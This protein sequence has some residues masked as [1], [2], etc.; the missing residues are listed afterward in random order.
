MTALEKPFVAV[1]CNP[2]SGSGGRRALLLDLVRVLRRHGL[3][4]R[5]FRNR[6]RLSACLQNTEYRDRLRCIV[7]AGGD[8]TVGDVINRFPGVPLAILPCGTE[9]LLARYLKIPASGTEVGEIIGKGA[10]RRIDLCQLGERRFAVVASAGFDAEVIHQAHAARTGHIT[11]LAYLEPI[12]NG[13]WTYTHPELEV[14]LDDAPAPLRGCLL[15][16]TNLPA[17]ALGLPIA[18]HALENDGL[19]D[20]HLFQRGSALQMARYLYSIGAGWHEQLSDVVAARAS[21]VRV[22]S[23]APV[24]MQVDGDPAGHAPAEIRVLPGAL[25]VF[26][27]SIEPG[28]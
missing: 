4:V 21:R 13:L 26:A 23:Q 28:G 7:A 6:E 5:V 8:G 15:I 2:N 27:P 19:V 18:P 10:T 25:D 9:N 22:A 17:Y 3:R 16:L 1:Q 14:W 24:P 12:F 20:V 11:R